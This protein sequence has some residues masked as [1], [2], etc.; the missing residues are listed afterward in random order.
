M[1]RYTCSD[2]SIIVQW[3]CKSY[4]N[5]M[6]TNLAKLGPFKQKWI[7]EAKCFLLIQNLLGIAKLC[8][9][10]L[11]YLAHFVLKIHFTSGNV[12]CS[13]WKF[14]WKSKTSPVS[15]TYFE[16]LQYRWYKGYKAMRK[17]CYRCIQGLFIQAGNM[18]HFKRWMKVL[19]LR[20]I[21]RFKRLFL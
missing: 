11:Q 12:S 6:L 13:L 5:Q 1:Y 21:N 15:C 14:I 8:S 20:F 7:F 17:V 2:Q 10:S 16:W 4:A 19:D 9:N 18:H 3:V